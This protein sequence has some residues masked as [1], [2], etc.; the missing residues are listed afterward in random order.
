MSSILAQAHQ[1]FNG[2]SSHRYE[3]VPDEERIYGSGNNS[4]YSE[5]VRDMI[6]GLTD[7]LTVPFA[8]AAG[9]SSL[10]NRYLIILGCL[11]GKFQIRWYSLLRAQDLIFTC[12]LC[13]FL[14]LI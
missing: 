13:H 1:I 4:Q 9:L 12:Y 10:G 7:G 8:L 6:F 2:N 11:T 3:T 14:A 5:I